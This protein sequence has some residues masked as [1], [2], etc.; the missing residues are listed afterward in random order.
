MLLWWSCSL[1]V[2]IYRG[3][4]A[5]CISAFSI[6]QEPWSIRLPCNYLYIVSIKTAILYFDIIVIFVV[7]IIND[8]INFITLL[9]MTAWVRGILVDVAL[10]LVNCIHWAV[11]VRVIIFRIQERINLHVR[12]THITSYV[13]IS[14]RRD[15]FI[16]IWLNFTFFN[17]LLVHV[18]IKNVSS[19]ILG[20][21]VCR[22]SLI[23]SCWGSG[24]IIYYLVL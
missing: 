8:L 19:C 2:S 13:E 7:G 6:C 24:V 23:R 9:F 1:S 3:Y 16:N 14:F 4:L 15:T 17:F 18:E 22:L 20:W 12:N 10:R 11:F 21:R 5:A